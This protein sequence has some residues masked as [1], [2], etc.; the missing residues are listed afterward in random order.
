MPRKATVAPHLALD[1][2]PHRYRH[3]HDPVARSH[4]QIV[5]LVAEGHR[6]PEV[7]RLVGYTANGVR[8]SVR[9]SNAAGSD[10]LV[11]QRTAHRGGNPPLL[12]PELKAELAERLTGPAPDGELWRC[13]QVATWMAERW[14][15][16]GAGRRCGR[17]GS[18]SNAHGHGPPRLIRS[19][20]TPSKQG[21]PGAGGFHAEHPDAAL[22]VWAMDEHRLGQRPTAWVRRRY[23]WL[24]VYGFVRPTTGQSWWGLVPTVN[25]QAMRAALAACAADRGVDAQHRVALMLDGAG[26]HTA[27]ALVVPEGVHLLFLPPVLPERP[28]TARSW[29]LGDEPVAHRTFADLDALKEV[30]VTR[31]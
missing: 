18:A 1:E 10:A 29:P 28:P 30:L 17:S 7:A 5:W 2:L 6:V 12:T 24:Y 9:R 21:A 25:A 31:W 20:R 13:H 19:R 22:T 15:T 4:W 3:A 8:E 23:Q 14:S 11:D 26:W 27:T 16:P